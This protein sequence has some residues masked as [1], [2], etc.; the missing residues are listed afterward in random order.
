M[1]LTYLLPDSK[2][3]KGIFMKFSFKRIVLIT[4]L[5]CCAAL[6]LSSCSKKTGDAI[7]GKWHDDKDNTVS[8]FKTDGSVT[9]MG[10][11]GSIMMSGTYKFTDD[12]HFTASISMPLPPEAK[13][14]APPGTPD[15]IA[16]TVDCTVKITGDEMDLD[17]K[18][19]VMG[20]P[21]QSDHSHLKRVK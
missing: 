5:A 16:L 4:C 18:M 20:Q 14:K 17:S 15:K 12:T 9:V 21:A 3:K 10:S 8:E 6:L 7:I 11:D 1:F 13:G 19:S 2:T